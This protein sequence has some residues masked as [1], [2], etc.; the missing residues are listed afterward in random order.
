MHFSEF[1]KIPDCPRAD[2]TRDLQLAPASTTIVNEPA[3][4]SHHG[5]Q[6]SSKDRAT[7]VA[8]RRIRLIFSWVSRLRFPLCI[9]PKRDLDL[10]EWRRLEWRGEFPERGDHRHRP[11]N[12]WHI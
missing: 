3:A 12:R 9:A 2:Q 4:E 6:E 1:K 5:N 11:S 10:A 7:S 8:A